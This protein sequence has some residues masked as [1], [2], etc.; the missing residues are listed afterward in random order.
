MRVARS[1]LLLEVIREM[2]FRKAE[3]FYISIGSGKTSAPT[4]VNKIL[5]RLKAGEAVSEER[6]TTAAPRG[7]HAMPATASGDMGIEVEGISDVLVRLAKCC[8]PVPGTGFSVTSHSAAGSPSTATTAERPRPAQEPRDRFGTHLVGRFQ[9]SRVPGRDRHR[10]VGSPSSARG[11]SRSFAESGV[12]IVSA[13]CHMENQMV[14][15]RFVVD[16][17][18]IDG[19]KGVISALRNVESVFDA[20][21]VTP[22]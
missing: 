21:R 4:V 14:H 15:D 13:N 16:V 3:D 12:N 17:G 8:K 19:L 7:R 18:D 1:P 9:S 6:Q 5:A 11:L 2:G 20:Y 10:R 22:G